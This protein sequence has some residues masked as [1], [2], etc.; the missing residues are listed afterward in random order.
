MID[1]TCVEQKD[2][3]F[4]SFFAKIPASDLFQGNRVHFNIMSVIS[5]RKAQT[6]IYF[7]NTT[8]PAQKCLPQG[9]LLENPVIPMRFKPRL[10]GC[11][12]VLRHF[13]S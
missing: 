3:Y 9:H 10:V 2:P 1:V 11:I 13:N 5:R 4:T 12:G 6:F 7:T 8:A